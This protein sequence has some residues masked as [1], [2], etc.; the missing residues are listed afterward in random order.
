M[1]LAHIISAI[2]LLTVAI[3]LNAQGPSSPSEKQA[4]AIFSTV[5]HENAPGLAVVVRKNGRT[6]F[7]KGYGV[8]DLRSNAKIGLQTNFRLASFTK[9]FT[10]IAVMLLVRDGELHYDQT[11]TEAFPDFPAY[12][13][14]ITIRN[15][16]NHTGGLPDYED[17]M[18]AQE[19][20]KGPLWSPERQIQDDEVLSFLKKETKGKS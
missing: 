17:L 9:Q 19:K 11:L 13:K 5:T 14:K 1:R 18:E 3:E 4:D 15:L 8:R 7:E 16:L 2:A 6:L 20:I 12:G 10:A